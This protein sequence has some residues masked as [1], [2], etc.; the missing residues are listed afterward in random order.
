MIHRATFRMAWRTRGWLYR[1]NG[2]WML[3]GTCRPFLLTIR[4]IVEHT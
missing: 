1:C 4:A 3:C 2:E